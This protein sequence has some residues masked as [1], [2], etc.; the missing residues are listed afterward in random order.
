MKA[1]RCLC[2]LISD[3]NI[4]SCTK[5]RS[6]STYTRCRIDCRRHCPLEQIFTPP[7][8][9][10]SVRAAG[11]V[12]S[13]T[14]LE[15]IRCTWLL[16]VAAAAH[17]VALPMLPD[18]SLIAPEKRAA[19]RVQDGQTESDDGHAYAPSKTSGVIHHQLFLRSR[20]E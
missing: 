18:E 10:I 16:V 3:D 12:I 6:P 7:P 8:L 2:L 9:S 1:Y 20:D 15:R 19:A 17:R 5:P 14:G 4:I 13:W 11:A